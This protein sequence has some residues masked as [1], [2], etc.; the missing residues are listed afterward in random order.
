MKNNSSGDPL[1]T[2]AH[3]DRRIEWLFHSSTTCSISLFIIC[4]KAKRIQSLTVE[5]KGNL[6]NTMHCAPK[7]S[8]Y[9]EYIVAYIHAH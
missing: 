8:Q 5:E 7:I 3:D 9:K 4:I 6:H 1:G 2:A